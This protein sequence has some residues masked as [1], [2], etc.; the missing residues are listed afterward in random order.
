MVVNGYG[1]ADL[2]DSCAHVCSVDLCES[3]RCAIFLI[4]RLPRDFDIT[5]LLEKSDP[6]VKTV[7]H[8]QDNTPPPREY[9]QLPR[10]RFATSSIQQL[11]S[12]ACCALG[13]PGLRNRSSFIGPAALVL[14]ER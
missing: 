1:A 3:S 13:L 12:I 11:V 2:R 4:A 14:A 9:I 7:S 5:D 6:R 10:Q 8:T